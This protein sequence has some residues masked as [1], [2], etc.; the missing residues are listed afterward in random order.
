MIFREKN[1]KYLVLLGALLLLPVLPVQALRTGDAAADLKLTYLSGREISLGGAL[2]LP[3]N[4]DPEKPGKLRL[5]ALVRA[6][7]NASRGL[8]PL[9]ED[10]KCRFPQV[11]IV[12]VC[13]DPEDMTRE[14][15]AGYPS[16]RFSAAWDKDR[17]SVRKYMAG[18][19]IY[20]RIFVI[21]SDGTILW[22]GETADV[23][24]MLS[25]YYA[26]RFDREKAKKI[27]PWLDDLSSR[28]RNG[29][30]RRAGFLAQQILSE[31]PGNAAALR[32]QLYLLENAGKLPEAWNLLEEQRK[33]SAAEAKVYLMT[34]TFAANHGSY[35]ARAGEI[36]LQ[37][38]YA[39]KDDPNA[40]GEIVWMLLTRFPFDANALEI[41][42]K[43]LG[44]AMQ[45]AGAGENPDLLT[46]AALYAARL[47]RFETA[48]KLQKKVVAILQAQFPHRS[49]G[50]EAMLQYY[51]K[52][53]EMAK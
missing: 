2:D 33:A 48:V 27:A 14:F 43:L 20:P 25:Q 40:D 8:L 39:V 49:A 11:E 22:D 42:G 37:Y 35:H 26:N 9:L 6:E 24:E 29:E 12:A 52:S 7:S 32:M 13:P 47:G 34:L 44:R 4:Q 10:W 41:S 31:D 3:E 38:L 45:S 16:Q 36:A 1:M 51:R 21:G 18:A 23:P 17:E 50:A 15:F 28:M 19:V 46:A 30:E 53:L 5:L